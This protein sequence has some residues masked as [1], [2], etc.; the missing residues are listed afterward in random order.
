MVCSTIGDLAQ[1]PSL[2]IT[3]VVDKDGSQRFHPDIFHAPRAPV[4]EP[5]QTDGSSS[6]YQP[7]SATRCV[8]QA[9]QTEMG[10]MK[11]QA[12]QMRTDVPAQY[13]TTVY[14]LEKR[15]G[16]PNAPQGDDHTES[17]RQVAIY[18]HGLDCLGLNSGSLRGFSDSDCD[19]YEVA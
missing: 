15:M 6:T 16:C 14:W 17:Y 11:E 13:G 19:K 12:I 7:E 4:D 3:Y 5:T 2:G 8:S 9:M 18:R 10:G 1:P